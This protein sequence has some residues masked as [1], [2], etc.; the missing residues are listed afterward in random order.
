MINNKLKPYIPLADMLAESLGNR[1]EVVIHDLSTPHNSV[2][3]VANGTITD[4]KIGQ[5]FDHLVKE[6]LLADGFKN[7][8]KANY[9]F[10]LA[11][12][13]KIKSST[14]IIKDENELMI[15]AFCINFEIDNLLKIQEFIDAFL[16][17]AKKEVEEEVQ[18]IDSFDSVSEIIDTLIDNIVGERNIKGMKRSDNIKLISFMNEKGIFLAKGSI[19]KVA[20]KL[21]V[22]PVTI[23]SYLDEIKKGSR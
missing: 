12:G 11:N 19:E 22:S 3:Y 7:D 1:C 23:Y 5:S 21:E 4:R 20:N 13:K 14:S 18:S 15:G 9:T 6:V 8:Y 10:E 2:V 16:P 17:S